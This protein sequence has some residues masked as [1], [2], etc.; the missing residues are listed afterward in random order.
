MTTLYRNIYMLRNEREKSLTD[1]W[2]PLHTYKALTANGLRIPSFQWIRKLSPET[3]TNRLIVGLEQ[4]ALFLQI[5]QS[6][7]SKVVF[8]HKECILGKNFEIFEKLTSDLAHLVNKISKKRK[9]WSFSNPLEIYTNRREISRWFQKCIT[10]YAY[11]A[12]L[13]RY[14]H[15]TVEKCQFLC[16]ASK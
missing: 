7:I 16:H 2:S 10:S 4:Y 11:F 3:R 1:F 6:P 12:Y 13:M 5:L 8:G 14:V 9:K 15:F